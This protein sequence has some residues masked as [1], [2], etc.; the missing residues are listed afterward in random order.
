MQLLEGFPDYRSA[1]SISLMVGQ[2]YLNQGDYQ[3]AKTYLERVASTAE[4][5]G[6]KEKALFLLGWVAYREERFDEVIA[7]FEGFL[8][9]YPSS[10]Y[11]D[12]SQYWMAWA[13]FRKKNFQKAQP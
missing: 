1:P 13:H 4:E 10:P 7:Q 12:E 5:S 6:D 3:R 11:R 8:Q 2:C 9:S